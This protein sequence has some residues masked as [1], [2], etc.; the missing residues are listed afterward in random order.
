MGQMITIHLLEAEDRVM[1]TDW[2]RPLQLRSM[3]GGHSDD[4]SFRSQ[5]S[6]T[7]ENN[8]LWAQAQHVLGAVWL[9]R[10]VSE[11]DR[12]LGGSQPFEFVRGAV[13]PSHQLDM[14]DYTDITLFA[15]KKQ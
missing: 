4:Y 2:C 6:G 5:Y 14:K 7:P 13:P 12:A 9:G 15:R 1:P 11:I 10:T 3:T 8:V